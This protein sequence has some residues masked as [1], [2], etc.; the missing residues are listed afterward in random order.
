[1]SIPRTA[2]HSSRSPTTVQSVARSSAAAGGQVRDRGSRG[3]KLTAVCP[4]AVGDCAG[5]PRSAGSACTL[6]GIAWWMTRPTM[7]AA[8]LARRRWTSLKL[9]VAEPEPHPADGIERITFTIKVASCVP[10]ACRSTGCG[11][12][13]SPIRPHRDHVLRQHEHVPSHP[14][15]GLRL[16]LHQPGDRDTDRAGIRERRKPWRRTAPFAS[17]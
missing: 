11:G 16:R 17:R 6:P 10:T 8:T 1:M 14:D 3:R 2:R 15:S 9:Y 7:L 12:C 13:S 5:A 4:I